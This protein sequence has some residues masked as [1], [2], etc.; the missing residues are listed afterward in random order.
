MPNLPGS[1]K[2]DKFIPRRMN[3]TGEKDSPAISSYRRWPTPLCQRRV[4]LEA[5]VIP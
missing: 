4:V 2:A 3:A 1:A 5:V